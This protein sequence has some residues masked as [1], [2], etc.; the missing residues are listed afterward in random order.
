[1]GFI[2]MKFRELIES[3]KIGVKILRQQFNN[4]D[5]ATKELVIF[6]ENSLKRYEER[7][8]KEDKIDEMD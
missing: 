2:D 1:M 5:E 4:L 7:K 6:L 3:Q 8:L